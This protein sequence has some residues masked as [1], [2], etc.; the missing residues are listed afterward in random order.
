[1]SWI[2]SKRGRWGG[3]GQGDIERQAGWSGGE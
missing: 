2:W 3:A 1:L